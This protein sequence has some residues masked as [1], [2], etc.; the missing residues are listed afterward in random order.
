[1]I[2]DSVENTS[3]EKRVERRSPTLRN[4]RIEIKLAGAPIYQ[5]RV[6]D[7]STAGAGILINENSG[8]M[9]M[10]AVGQ[11]MDVNFISPKGSEPSGMFRV[12]IRH[13]TQMERSKY[14]GL[15]LVGIRILDR[16][17]TPFDDT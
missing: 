5:F 15:R 11:V 10:I 1:M 9:R 17:D 4:H 13:M 14:K 3:E 6:T 16:L 12:E 2:S 7:V 8:F